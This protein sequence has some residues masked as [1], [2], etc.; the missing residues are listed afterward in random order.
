MSRAA[1]ICGVGARAAG[2]Q[3][4]AVFR[5]LVSERLLELVPPCSLPRLLRR[6]RPC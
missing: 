2:L 1:A 4:R 6:V 3:L 5:A